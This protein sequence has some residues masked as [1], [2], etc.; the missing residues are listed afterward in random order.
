MAATEIPVTL[1]AAGVPENAIW[2]LEVCNACRYCEG[3]C[4]VFP[5]LERRRIFNKADLDYLS[6]LCFDCRHCYYACMFSPPHEYAVNLPQMLAA[7][8]R[9]TYAQYALPSMFMRLVSTNGYLLGLLFAAVALFFVVGIAATGDPARL[10]SVQQGSGA[11]YRIIPYTLMFLPALIISV[12]GLAVMVAGGINFWRHTRGS[13]RDFLDPGAILTAAGD[14]LGLRYQMGGGAGGCPYPKA[15]ASFARWVLH[16]LTFWGFLSAFLATCIA[17][18]HEHFWGWYAPFPILSGPVIFGSLG[19]I[20]MIV[21][22]TGLIYL[23]QRSDRTPSD[24]KSIEM[25]YV[26]LVLLNLVNVSGMALLIFRETAAMGSLLVIHLATVFTLYFA[27][28]YSKFAHFVYRY[29]ALVQ[30]R[31]EARRGLLHH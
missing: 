7:V 22:T 19:G 1:V 16:H 26:F 21:G 30:D 14:A 8:R 2:Q 27:M 17:Y 15:S 11:F 3:Y 6:N 4:A 13:L 12:A 9:E 18:V 28:P 29:A 24:G 10:F 25:D 5:A 31:L 23:K 20:A